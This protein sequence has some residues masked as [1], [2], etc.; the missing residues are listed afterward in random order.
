ME[1]PKLSFDKFYLPNG[2]VNKDK[3][4]IFLTNLEL[5]PTDKSIN[6][7]D[8]KIEIKVNGNIAKYINAIPYMAIDE[9][10]RLNPLKTAQEVIDVWSPFK[11]IQ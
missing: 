6:L 8:S 7:I 3:I 4:K 9:Y 1:N 10:V 2:K 5:E 11:N